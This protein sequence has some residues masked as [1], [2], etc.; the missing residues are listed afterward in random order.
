MSIF[1]KKTKADLSNFDSEQ[2]F[3]DE[4]NECIDNAVEKGTQSSEDESGSFKALFTTSRRMTMVTLN[5]AYQVFA[6]FY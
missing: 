6:C 3:L 1:L 4:L 2:E 5:V